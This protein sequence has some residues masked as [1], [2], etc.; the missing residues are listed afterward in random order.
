ML[1]LCNT[2]Y[3]FPL[4]PEFHSR[5]YRNFVLK[6]L[7]FKNRPMT[8]INCYWN[9]W[10]CNNE[11]KKF[12]GLC[13]CKQADLCDDD[14]E[15][16]TWHL[17]QAQ[18]NI[19]RRSWDF[20]VG[21]CSDTSD[22]TVPKRKSVYAL[23]SAHGRIIHPVTQDRNLG[24]MMDTSLPVTPCSQG[25]QLPLLTVFQIWSSPLPPSLLLM[26]VLRTSLLLSWL[27][28]SLSSGQLE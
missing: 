9:V 25:L 23:M 24:V 26:L 19:S 1:F 5:H 6:I 14:S 27:T 22:Q 3:F 20:P 17:A 10:L 16:S 12:P 15:F 28:S 13:V 4:A 18:T 11:L 21:C 8:L 2:S 7:H